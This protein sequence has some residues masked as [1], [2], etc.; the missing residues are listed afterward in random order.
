M[1]G[2][3]DPHVATQAVGMPAIPSWTVKPFF[4][5]TSVMYFDV[6]TSWKPSSP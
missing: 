2:L 5:R 4:L 3:P 1:T 6:S